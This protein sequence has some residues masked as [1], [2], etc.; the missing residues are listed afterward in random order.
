MVEAIKF[1]SCDRSYSGCVVQATW[2]H[3]SRFN[4]VQILGRR[5]IDDIQ[6]INNREEIHELWVILLVG[7]E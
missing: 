3:E 5:D 2:E 4:P 7:N 6:P 1:A